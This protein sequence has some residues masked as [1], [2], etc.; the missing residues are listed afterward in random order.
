MKMRL[1]NRRTPRRISLGVARALL[2]AGAAGSMA[3]CSIIYDLGADQCN[4]DDDCTALGGV[5]VG[6]VCSDNICVDPGGCLT[7]SDCMDD[8]DGQFGGNPGT[9]QICRQ[10]Q[11]IS[12]ASTECPVVLPLA[13]SMATDNLRA[14]N[15]IILGGFANLPEG[16]LIG[17]QVRNYDLVVT[18]VSRQTGGLYATSGSERRPVVMVVCQSNSVTREQL[19]ASMVHLTDRLRVPGVVSALLSDD[20]QYAFESKGLDSQTFFMSTFEGD[21]T[22]T[23]LGD[24][25]LLWHV[26]PGGEQLAVAYAPLLDRAITHM[27]LSGTV[28]VATVTARDIRLLTDIRDTIFSDP[29]SGGITF[30]GKSAVDNLAD[31]NYLGI[32]VPSV[33]EDPDASLADEAQ[34]LLAFQPSVVIGAGADEFFSKIVVPLERDWPSGSGAPPRPFYLV[35][36]YAFNNPALRALLQSNT[37]G[38][39]TRM[40]GINAPS[41]ADQSLY[42]GYLGRFT[43]EY[44]EASNYVGYENFYDAAYYLVYAIA[45][46]ATSFRDGRDMA[47]PGMRQLLGG[48]LSLGVGP[49]DMGQA[50]DNLF[51]NT[52]ITLNGTMGPPD[53]NVLTGAR[54]AFGSVWCIDASLAPQS[55]VL[56]Y[57]ATTKT[58]DGDFPCFTF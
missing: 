7:N 51:N 5:F 3:S 19:D 57:N 21:R 27:N 54:N 2:V 30:N 50:M 46:A 4:N 11:C 36:P 42:T 16:T 34:R 1:D 28:K 20:L 55:D 37:T 44:P 33:Y 48:N 17:N 38:V 29:S 41:A 53:F 58:L 26:L 18:E 23:T 9:P 56:R 13:D 22:L 6:K 49:R 45:G 43:S 24:N 10:R 8:V 14:S 47:S 40:A 31:E 32:N 15:P 25:N 12:L 39:R 52:A 35:S